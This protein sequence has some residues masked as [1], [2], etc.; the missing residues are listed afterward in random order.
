[1]LHKH[2]SSE[3]YRSGTVR[4]SH[5]CSLLIAEKANQLWRKVTIFIS[6]CKEATSQKRETGVGALLIARI[7]NG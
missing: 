1:M 4:D 3:N 7:I 6:N 2:D 5:P